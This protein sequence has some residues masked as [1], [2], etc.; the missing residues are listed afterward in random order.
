ML[1]TSGDYY[2]L[3]DKNTISNIVQKIATQDASRFK[4]TPRVTR[5]DQPQLLLYGMLIIIIS[6]IIIDWRLRI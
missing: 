2:A 4:G 5:T 3:R 1:A 6:L